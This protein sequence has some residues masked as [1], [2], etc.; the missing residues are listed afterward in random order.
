MRCVIT[1]TKST[2]DQ[3]FAGAERIVGSLGDDPPLVTVAELQKADCV[4]DDRVEMELSATGAVS[5]K[6]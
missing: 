6:S 1:Y 3:D 4:Q 5:F 2:R